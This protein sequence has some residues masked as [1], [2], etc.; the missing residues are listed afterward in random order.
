[1]EFESLPWYGQFAVIF[2]VA[3]ALFGFGFWY[4]HY[5]GTE[6]TITRLDEEIEKLDMEIRKAEREEKRLQDI[7]A[8]LA[9]S[10]A[11]LE[12]LK[13]ILPEEEQVEQILR[14]V[15]TNISNSRLRLNNFVPRGGVPPKDVYQER[16][17]DIT[18]TGSY[19]NLAIFMDQISNMKKIF[20]IDNLDLK[21]LSRQNGEFT[22]QAK[23]VA[24]TYIYRDASAAGGQSK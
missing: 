8:Q 6:T 3:G 9:S 7:K 16:P 10:E 15:Q 12:T 14:D 5:D 20:T 18:L 17:V 1:M 19:H 4:L 2:L 13:Q 21:P 24:T 11:Q 23:F 22:L